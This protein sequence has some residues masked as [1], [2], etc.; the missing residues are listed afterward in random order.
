MPSWSR[1]W[2]RPAV[3]T[4]E[5]ISASTSSLEP[6][7]GC[8]KTSQTSSIHSYG[9]LLRREKVVKTTGT[10]NGVLRSLSLSEE[11]DQGNACEQ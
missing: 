10:Y 11:G 4:S 2:P 7:T 3:C 1:T 6:V 5:T 9:L 8:N